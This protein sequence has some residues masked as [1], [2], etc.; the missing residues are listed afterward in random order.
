MDV[1]DGSQRSE[2]LTV[3]GRIAQHQ[4]RIRIINEGWIV[5][6]RE[7]SKNRLV[8]ETPNKLLSLILL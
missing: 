6:F 7:A 8:A 1:P 2:G 3:E 5:H 4:I